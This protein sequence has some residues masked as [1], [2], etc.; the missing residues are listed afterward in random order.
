MLK[1]IIK[2][3]LRRKS[4]L[5]DFAGN[6]VALIELPWLLRS[7][8][9]TLMKKFGHWERL[10]WLSFQVISRLEQILTPQAKVLEFG[11]GNSSLWLVERCGLLVTIDNDP[12]WHQWL[13]ARLQAPN[14]EARLRVERDDYLNVDDYPDKFFD[15]VIVDGRWRDLSA[16]R[17]LRKVR[18]GGY[19]YIDNTDVQDEE[20]QRAKGLLLA[21]C[22]RAEVLTGF[23][24]FQV[25]VSQGILARID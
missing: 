7:V 25:M 12:E 22:P 1:R 14:V 2:G 20:H 18:P 21:A 9:S 3:D 4:R 8:W 6:R 16:E 5:H 13:A 24:T 19:V 10:P 15:L 11:S 23:T 17:A